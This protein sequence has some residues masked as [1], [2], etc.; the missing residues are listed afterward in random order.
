MFPLGPLFIYLWLSWTLSFCIS[1]SISHSISVFPSMYLPIYLFLLISYFLCLHFYLLLSRS[2]SKIL[3]QG[4]SYEQRWEVLYRRDYKRVCVLLVQGVCSH[5]VISPPSWFYHLSP[6]YF[7]SYSDCI[8]IAFTPGW[9]TLQLWGSDRL[10]QRQDTS[11]ICN[12]GMHCG[13]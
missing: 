9:D 7:L 6:S 2:G 5:H 11:A 13:E 1:L 8:L 4:H 3:Y 12:W 10:V